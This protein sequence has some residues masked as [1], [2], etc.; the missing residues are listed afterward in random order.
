GRGSAENRE[1]GDRIAEARKRRVVGEKELNRL[2]GL[3]MLNEPDVGGEASSS[4]L[5]ASGK[6]QE[7]SSFLV[8]QICNLLYRRLAVCGPSEMPN[9]AQERSLCRLQIGDIHH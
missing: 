8:A 1:A 2:K 7:H 4:K 5:Q 6:F 9:P 3:N